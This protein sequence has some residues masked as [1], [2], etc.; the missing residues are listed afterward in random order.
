MCVCVC[1]RERERERQQTN[2]DCLGVVFLQSWSFSSTF[3]Q[4][5]TVA[6]A[7]TRRVRLCC[8]FEI[9]MESIP[10]HFL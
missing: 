10:S 6:H 8:S 7:L 5:N 4:G 3:K 2:I 9:W 1:E